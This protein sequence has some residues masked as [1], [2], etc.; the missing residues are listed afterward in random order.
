MRWRFEWARYKK[1]Q[2][3]RLTSRSWCTPE[4]S[5]SLGW[6]EKEDPRPEWSLALETLLQAVS[7]RGYRTAERERGA[8]P[9]VSKG[10]SSGQSAW[11]RFPPSRDEEPG[12]TAPL[13]ARV[14]SRP[15]VA[16]LARTRI[17]QSPGIKL[18]K[19]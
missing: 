18:N 2:Q 9:E 17:H 8:P 6:K 19:P 16:L 11:F 13:A 5:W 12:F 15:G 3:K 4:D 10:P 7:S 1:K 14:P